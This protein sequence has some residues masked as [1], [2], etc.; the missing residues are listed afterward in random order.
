MMIVVHSDIE[1]VISS[2]HQLIK[3]LSSKCKHTDVKISI[4]QVVTM[5]KTVPGKNPNPTQSSKAVKLP[6]KVKVLQSID[7]DDDDTKRLKIY[8]HED[9][10]IETVLIKKFANKTLADPTKLHWIFFFFQTETDY[11]SGN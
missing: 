5:K 11:V 4:F 6:T 7:Q 1:K 9:L 8:L 10:C 3:D 2:V